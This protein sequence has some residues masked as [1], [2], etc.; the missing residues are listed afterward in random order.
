MQGL[1]G[2]NRADRRTKLTEV[3]AAWAGIQVGA[4]MELR[5]EEDN[6]E[7]QGPKPGFFTNWVHVVPKED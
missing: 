7:E 1:G 4:K 2:D 6:P 5:R 3:R